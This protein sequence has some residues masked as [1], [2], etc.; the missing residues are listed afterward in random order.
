LHYSKTDTEGPL[1]GHP[2]LIQLFRRRQQI[3]SLKAS[4]A[5]IVEVIR[6]TL[7]D[8][9]LVLR[10][11]KTITLRVYEPPKENYISCLFFY[12]HIFRH[13]PKD[14]PYAPPLLQVMGIA[15][16]FHNLLTPQGMV[17]A[18]AHEK[19]LQWQPYHPLGKVVQDVAQIFA[20]ETLAS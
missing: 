7:L 18:Q 3:D 8:V 17:I 9:P 16:F 20:T 5:T 13:L 19:L 12:P 15:N 4:F 14:F 10:D 1:F 2:L 6:E 11:R